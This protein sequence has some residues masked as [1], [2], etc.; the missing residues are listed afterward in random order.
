MSHV[1]RE[2]QIDGEFEG[3]A[4]D[5]LFKLKDGTFWLQTDH[6]L[7]RYRAST[8][9]AQI[10]EIID[11]LFL[12]IEE[13]TE[14]ARVRQIFDV[15]ESKINGIFRGWEGETSYE[16]QNGQIWQQIR[17]Q[18]ENKF[19][20]RPDVLI[21]NTGSETLMRVEGTTVSVRRTQ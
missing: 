7:W 1:I 9:K 3:F 14:I 17:Y 16:L 15:V 5:K 19:A 18:F 8:P 6:T 13:E 11:Q 20:Y 10:V 21:Y 4:N 12:Q 2:S